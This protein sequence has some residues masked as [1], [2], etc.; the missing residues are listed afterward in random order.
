MSVV[1]IE[2]ESVVTVVTD[3]NDLVVVSEPGLM[4]PAAAL[5]WEVSIPIVGVTFASEHLLRYDAPDIIVLTPADCYG[6]CDTLAT[7]NA[8]FVLKI[9]NTSVTNTSIGT[10]TFTANSRIASVSITANTIN[11]R[12]ILNVYAPTTQDL[13]LADITI[14]LKGER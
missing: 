4:G 1:I 10:I 6:S 2:D 14:T 5:P 8:A 13:T 9:S 11:K 12:D 3:G 7:A